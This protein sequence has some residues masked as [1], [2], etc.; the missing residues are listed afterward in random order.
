MSKKR[1][2]TYTFRCDEELKEKF[3]M[4]CKIGKVSPSS[5]LQ[6]VMME[7]CDNAEKIMNMEDITELRNLFIDKMNIADNEIKK[8]EEY[9]SF[10]R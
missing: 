6:D 2:S 9:P 7:F 3:K 1:N 10:K 4:L 8:I 5:V